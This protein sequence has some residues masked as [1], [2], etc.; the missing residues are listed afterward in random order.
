M[1]TI[2]ELRKIDPELSNVSDEELIEVRDELYEIGQSAF[3][4]FWKKKYGSK[5]PVGLLLDVSNKDTI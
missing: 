4:M 2:T 5:N 3:D 1:I